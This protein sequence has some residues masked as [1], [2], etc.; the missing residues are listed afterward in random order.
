[1]M[2]AKE[3]Y[4]QKEVDSVNSEG[5]FEEFICDFESKWLQYSNEETKVK[6]YFGT[7]E[8]GVRIFNAWK[9]GKNNFENERNRAFPKPYRLT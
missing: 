3:F 4:N 1:M 8:N 2:T 9:N 5:T 6:A 7:V